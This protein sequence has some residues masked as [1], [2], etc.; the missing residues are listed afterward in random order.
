MHHK[1]A[2]E[3]WPRLRQQRAIIWQLLKTAQD[4]RM[5][6]GQLPKTDP[7]LIVFRDQKSKVFSPH[8]VNKMLKKS[9]L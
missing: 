9:F 2:I 3:A 4:T 7:D 5:E 6:L 8:P 1:K